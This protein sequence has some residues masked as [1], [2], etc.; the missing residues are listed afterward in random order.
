MLGRYSSAVGA[1]AVVTAA[2]IFGMQ[3][4][5][6]EAGSHA[7]PSSPALRLLA[8][9]PPE[10]PLPKPRTPRPE[11]PQPRIGPPET[12]IPIPTTVPA[13]PGD[14][15]TPTGPPVPPAW[16]GG[17]P[18]P[19]AADS[20]VTLVA[21]VRP[22]YP[23]DAAVKGLEGYVVVEFTVTRRGEVDDVRVVESTHRQFE[24]AAAAAVAKARYRPRVVD[25]LAVDAPGQRT[26]IAFVLDD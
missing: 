4:L 19:W 1:G 9:L 12:P 7:P 15:A 11:P 23:Y 2:L 3:Q 22:P 16:P 10:P 25:G 26:R 21:Q 20:E 14:P 13:V 18:G 24:R 8:P 5:I 17:R 6:G